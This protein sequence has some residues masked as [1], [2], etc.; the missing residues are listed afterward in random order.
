MVYAD[1]LY[2]VFTMLSLTIT[3]CCSAAVVAVVNMENGNFIVYIIGTKDVHFSIH[4]KLI[5]IKSALPC[6]TFIGFVFSV[7]FHRSN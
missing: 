4:A 6:L 5:P 1:C 2:T 3:L 7:E